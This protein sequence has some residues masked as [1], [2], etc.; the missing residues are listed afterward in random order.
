VKPKNYRYVLVKAEDTSPEI[1]NLKSYL[2]AKATDPNIRGLGNE[3]D[4]SEKPGIA[5]ICLGEKSQNNPIISN[6]KEKNV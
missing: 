2:K 6:I 5:I 1:E 4:S 3:D